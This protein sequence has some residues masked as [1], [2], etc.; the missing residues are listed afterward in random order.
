MA[1]E[2]DWWGKQ[3]FK[4]NTKKVVLSQGGGSVHLNLLLDPPLGGLQGGGWGRDK[5]LSSCFFWVNCWDS[6]VLP[7]LSIPK[8]MPQ[9]VYRWGRSMLVACLLENFPF[10]SLY[11]FN[12]FHCSLKCFSKGSLFP[13]FPKPLGGSQRLIFAPI[14]IRAIVQ[15][16]EGL[17][18]NVILYLRYSWMI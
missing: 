6:N 15:D 11:P 3:T 4:E 2:T 14:C 13:L 8:K 10:S 16:R 18:Y 1:F 7:H 9:V 17:Q 5:R 12:T